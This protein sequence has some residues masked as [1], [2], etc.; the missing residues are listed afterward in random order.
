MA[1]L[2]SGKNEQTDRLNTE[3]MEDGGGS[4]A[5]RRDRRPDS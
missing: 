5:S 3:T 2:D 1:V 4:V